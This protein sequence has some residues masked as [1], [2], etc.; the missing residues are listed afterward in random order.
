MNNN[1]KRCTAI[2]HSKTRC[3]LNK[4]DN[5]DYCHRHQY[6]Y[7]YTNDNI[8]PVCT[9]KIHHK[10]PVLKCG[11]RIHKICIYRS[12][13][14]EC[15]ICRAVVTLN[16]KENNDYN[17]FKQEKEFEKLLEM[18]ENDIMEYMNDDDEQSEGEDERSE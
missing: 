16:T 1:D 9:E 2:T 13:K 15:P 8:C 11:H 5:N 12:M 10:V 18:L 3:K 6:I 14:L 7:R 17:I 4:G